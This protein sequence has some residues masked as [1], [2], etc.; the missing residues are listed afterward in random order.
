MSSC[1]VRLTDPAAE[2]LGH[3]E[4]AH[5]TTDYPWTEI[6]VEHL[7]THTSG[8]CDYSNS[9]SV[10]RDEN[11]GWQA[12][13]D[14]A[15]TVPSKWPYPNDAFTIARAK[16]EQNREPAPAPGSVLEY[17]NVAHALMNYV[18][19]R[20]CGQKLTDIF[21]LYIKQAGM[22]PPVGTSLISTDDG[23]QFNQA[24][25][26]AKWKGLD[27]AA[28]LRLAGRLGIWDNKNVEP[29]RY[30]HLLTRITGNIPAAAAQG[31]GVVYEN[32]SK[33]M[34]TQSV[35]HRR[36]SPEMF[37]HNG[38][39]STIFL[40]DPL[41][42]TI[43]VRQGENNAKGASYLTTN[44][45]AP[46]WTGLSPTCTA[47]TNYSNNWSTTSVYTSQRKKVVEPVQEAFFFPPPFCRMTSAGGAIVDRESDVYTTPMDGETVDLEA[48]I[49][50]NPREGAGSSV[51]DKVEFYV[52]TESAPPALIGLGTPVPGNPGRYQISYPAS[53]HGA[54]GQVKTYFASCVA[55]STQISTRKV[56]SYSG[57]VRVER[58]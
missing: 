2:W 31:W 30:W 54:V 17:S 42:G 37:G 13:F 41:S 36:L 53:S 15:K 14:H 21:N 40:N 43:I 4:G 52:E 7:A 10:C 5:W 44:G 32:N 3:G 9:S 27:G 34:W 51:A 50:V 23:Q 29:V 12:A 58:L 33:N 26:T 38:N 45:C 48:E 55:R 18:V 1:G 35:N 57:P 19:Q 28:V 22:G 49:T 39:Y 11:P 47:G 46:G 6:T 20:A 24:T 16:A 56:P 8:I 25:G